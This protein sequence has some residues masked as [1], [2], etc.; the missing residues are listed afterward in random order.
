M[1]VQAALNWGVTNCACSLGMLMQERK[2][3]YWLCA[4]R[5]LAVPGGGRSPR[6]TYRNWNPD[7]LSRMLVIISDQSS[8]TDGMQRWVSAPKTVAV[9]CSCVFPPLAELQVPGPG[10]H[11]SLDTYARP[12]IG[13]EN[14]WNIEH[15][16]TDL[17]SFVIV[18]SLINRG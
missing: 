18:S 6:L 3:L 17:G 1:S 8:G 10:F 12:N 13:M 2:R 5:I 16:R 4:W 7:I 11:L 15:P 14:V 9:D